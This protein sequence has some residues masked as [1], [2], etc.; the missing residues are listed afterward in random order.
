M[1]NRPPELSLALVTKVQA[2]T[3]AVCFTG[4]DMEHTINGKV[5]REEIDLSRPFHFRLIC[6]E[7]GQN[8]GARDKQQLD[9]VIDM[10]ER[11]YGACDDLDAISGGK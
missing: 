2:I 8:V 11:A 9:D 5:W 10:F 6:D 3:P 4:D 1:H 7:T